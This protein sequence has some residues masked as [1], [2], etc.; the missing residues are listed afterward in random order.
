MALP[1]ESKRRPSSVMKVLKTMVKAGQIMKTPVNRKNGID[2][3]APTVYLL[4]EFFMR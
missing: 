1:I 4:V 2:A 3:I